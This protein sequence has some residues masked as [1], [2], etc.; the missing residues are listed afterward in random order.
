M[1]TQ[2]NDTTIGA[3]LKEYE[4]KSHRVYFLAY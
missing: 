1:H 2:F 3:Y 4:S